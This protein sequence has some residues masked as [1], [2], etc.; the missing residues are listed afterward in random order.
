MSARLHGA[1]AAL[2]VA[3]LALRLP[4]LGQSLYGD[5]LFSYA[6][7]TRDGFRDVL[8]G[9]RDTENTPPA[10][11][12]LSWLCTRV[13]ETPEAAR[14]PSLV[15]GVAL[16]PL[17]G[18]L[19]ARAFAPAAG[20]IAAAIVAFSPFSIYYAAEA[21][22]YAAM[23]A[24]VAGAL[25]A[26]LLLLERDRPGRRVAFAV[27]AAGAVWLHY[28]AVFA[29]AAAAAWALLAR[30]ERR[31]AVLIAGAAAAVL[32]VPWLPFF[33]SN[34]LEQVIGILEPSSF[35]RVL[36]DPVRALVG[37][38]DAGLGALPGTVAL[39]VLA[40]AVAAGL[41]ASRG[42]A[43]TVPGALIVI[44]A[45]ATPA[46]IGLYS[47][48]GSSLQLPRNLSA[49][50]PA[51]AALTGALVVAIPGRRTRAAAALAVVAV[52]AVAGVRS[53]T[54]AFRRPPLGEAAAFLDAR[55]Q[56]GEPVVEALI[57][58][59]GP[60]LDQG[61]KLN[62]ERPHPI[63]DASRP[64]DRAWD[65]GLRAGRVWVVRPDRTLAP[66]RGRLTDPRFVEA[67]RR[68]F[69]GLIGIEVIGYEPR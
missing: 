25:L 66:A 39:V 9:V 45:L 33:G 58:P 27:L 65:A 56:P 17:T 53:T 40:G 67:E 62:L 46:G 18:L 50:I 54:E 55:A 51:L 7:V 20:P 43:R 42:R 26:L 23:A 68:R 60:P 13:S 47:L 12:V 6:I 44:A 24:C 37:H 28:T 31:R 48:A 1:L 5:E 38:P 59:A 32:Y 36:S 49:S 8:A 4:G 11:Y 30:P 16:V 22:A 15:G 64:T 14:L 34:G 41:A 2:T 69:D 63:L 19:T 3:A 52:L 21:R 29:L 57:F 35:G 10:F 61:L